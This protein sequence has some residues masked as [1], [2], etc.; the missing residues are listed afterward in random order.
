VIAPTD[1]LTGELQSA[2]L[3]EQYE[4]VLVRAQD[5]TVTDQNEGYGEWSV[6]NTGFPIDECRVDDEADITY[7]PANGAP[8]DIIGVVAY[9]FENYKIEP[10][11]DD[12]IDGPSDV[13]GGGIG[14]KLELAQNR[15]NPF[16]PKTAIAFNL[17]QAADVSLEIYDVAGRRVTTLVDK[18]LEAGPYSYEWDGKNQHGERVASGV[19]FYRLSTADRELSKK[20]VLLK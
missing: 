8:A 6:S 4:S 9:S 1:I 15:P 20:M 19:Y 2:N 10:R 11:G 12:D 7:E 13:P 17:P 16:N 5:C 18:R 3:G 14:R